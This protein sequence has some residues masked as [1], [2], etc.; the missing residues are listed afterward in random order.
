MCVQSTPVIA[1]N[2]GTAVWWSETPGRIGAGDERYEEGVLK[3]LEA[4]EIC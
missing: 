2:V 3:W 1:D 4:G